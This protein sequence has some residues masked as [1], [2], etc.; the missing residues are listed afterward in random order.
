MEKTNKYWSTLDIILFIVLIIFNVFFFS[1]GAYSI[2]AWISYIFFHIAYIIV[3]ITPFV[4]KKRKNPPVFG[5]ALFSTMS[6]IYFFLTLAAS[7]IFIIASIENDNVTQMAQYIQ[8]YLPPYYA[9]IGSLAV[10]ILKSV[11]TALVVHLSIA[12]IYFILLIIN[13]IANEHTAK[14]LEIRRE[15]IDYIK[16]ASAKL[17]LLLDKVNDK[18]TKRKVESVYDAVYSSPV[19]SHF[20]LI[21]IETRILQNINMLEV[22]IS[23][24][25]KN[26]IVLLS[27]KLLTDVNERNISLKMFN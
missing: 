8:R 16:I 4:I 14:A 15:Q 10:S 3:F 27:D 6:V 7:L 22:E 9:L 2:P 1:L 5:F 13:V 18:E 21:D 19:K 20:E 25:N 26:N 24:N 17:K 12:G 23:V 11:T